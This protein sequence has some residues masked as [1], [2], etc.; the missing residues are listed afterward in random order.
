MAL[1]KG[2]S[3]INTRSPKKLKFKS[4]Q[5]KREYE[6]YMA[7]KDDLKKSLKPAPA[8]PARLKADYSLSLI[9]I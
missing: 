8:K 2:L 7:W 9:H 6:S 5:E 1:V 3:T 4:A